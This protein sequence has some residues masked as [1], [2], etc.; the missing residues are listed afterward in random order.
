MHTIVEHEN[1]VEHFHY[2]FSLFPH[3][4]GA[5][6]SFMYTIVQHKNIVEYFHYIFPFNP[7][8]SLQRRSLKFFCLF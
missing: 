5:I 1:I 7:L 4:K 2:V 3:D 6:F 8:A